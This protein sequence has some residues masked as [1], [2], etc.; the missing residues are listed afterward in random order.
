MISME[1]KCVWQMYQIY[2]TNASISNLFIYFENGVLCILR[3]SS[4]DGM[5]TSFKYVN[6]TMPFYARESMTPTEREIAVKVVAEWKVSTIVFLPIDQTNDICL[7]LNVLILF[8]I[9]MKKLHLESPWMRAVC[10]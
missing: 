8:T 9:E 7:E 5:L 4:D 2:K 10:S 3:Q 1:R 6:K